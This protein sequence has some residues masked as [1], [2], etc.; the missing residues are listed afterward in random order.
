MH[1][2]REWRDAA[3]FA[4]FEHSEQGGFCAFADVLGEFDLGLQ[5]L[6]AVVELLHGVHFHVVAV[7]AGAAVCGAGDEVFF[8]DFFLQAVEHAAFC[9]DDDVFC[10]GVFAVADHF[11]RRADFVGEEA[12]GG[13][14]FR[15]GDDEGVRV[16]LLDFV[17][18]AAGE[19]DVDEAGAVPEVHFASGLFH[20]PCAEVGIRDEE[21]GAVCGGFFDDF[22]GIAGCA[23]DVAEGFDSGGAVDVGDDVV[24]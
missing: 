3:L 18:G 16:L 12:D 20:D 8:R 10:R 19:L 22:D 13:G 23:D 1:A 5:A 7:I 9:D 11:F 14:A 4:L 2:G 17:D 15:V 6:K 21:N 24:V